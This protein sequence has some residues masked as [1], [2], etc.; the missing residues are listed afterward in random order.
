[1]FRFHNLGLVEF[2]LLMFNSI[3]C[4]VG[5]AICAVIRVMSRLL[6]MFFFIV[7]I[8]SMVPLLLCRW[9]THRI[10]IASVY[11]RGSLNYGGL[12]GSKYLMISIG[13]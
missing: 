8:C 1:V 13:I 3:L 12:V 10:L 6:H 7:S 9:C 2:F 4:G 5:G 11:V